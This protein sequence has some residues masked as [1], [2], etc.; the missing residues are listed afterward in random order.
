MGDWGTQYG[1]LTAGLDTFASEKNLDDITLSEIVNVSLH[2]ID[3][4]FNLWSNLIYLF[5]CADLCGG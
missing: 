3:I 2:F 5:F 1:I 4:N